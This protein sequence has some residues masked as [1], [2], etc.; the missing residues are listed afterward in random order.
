MGAVQCVACLCRDGANTKES[1]FDRLLLEGFA[2]IEKNGEV[3]ASQPSAI[4][5]RIIEGPL[6][7]QA[8]FSMQHF[9]KKRKPQIKYQSVTA[10]PLPG[11]FDFRQVS[12]S[13]KITVIERAAS[14]KGVT[15]SSQVLVC[16]SPLAFGHVLFVPCC[17]HLPQVLT[18]E[19]IL[20]A[21]DLLSKSFRK[22]LRVLFNS[23]MAH[24][25]VNHFH[26]HGLYLDY[27]ELT[28]SMFPIER[29]DRAVIAGSLAPG[30][31]CVEMVFENRWPVRSFALMAGPP[32]DQEG[33]GMPQADVNALASITASLVRELQRNNIAHSVVFCPFQQHA[34]RRDK[35]Q[36]VLTPR[37][38]IIPR[39]AESELREDAGFNGAV[40]E[41]SGL[42]VAHSEQA[43]DSFSEEALKDIFSQDISLDAELFD[44]LI[45]KAAWLAP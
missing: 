41:V 43:F 38:F 21:L 42:L 3:L 45:C 28:D 22:D 27:C 6:G 34:L 24:S 39:K 30:K 26:L 1:P 32:K 10:Q 2:T 12:E 35:E 19:L 7:L 25:T 17:E 20:C 40:L 33:A 29:V 44:Q 18:E 23:L 9:Q 5:R 8:Q 36:V 4:R 31:V 13:E 11:T 37:I 14:D 15:V 16:L